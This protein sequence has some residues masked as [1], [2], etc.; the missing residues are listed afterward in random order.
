MSSPA[1]KRRLVAGNW[2]MNLDL[3][4]GLA[5]A[6]E[7]AAALSPVGFPVVLCAPAI[8]LAPLREIV[9][10][11]TDLALGAQD[12]SRHES[13]AHTGEVSGA[14]LRSA[15]CDYVIVGHSE[16]RADHVE[17][18]AVLREKV[19]R[20][21]AVGLRPIYCFGETLEQRDADEVE[22]V[23]A[24]QLAEGLSHLDGDA[25]GRVVLAYEPVWAIGTG[26]TASPEQAQEVHA[27]VRE[28]VGRRFGGTRAEHVSILY[29]GSVKPGNAAE[30][31]G[32]ADIDGGLIGGASLRA[33][34]V[35]AIV[36]AFV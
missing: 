10:E 29:G 28:W 19:D 12:L 18:G 31:F 4:A 27:F 30:L 15:G 7:C 20:A 8:H 33:A 22:K 14:Q 35:L 26:R 32:Q 11:S 9:G 5:L 3:D 2:K 1:S 17:A 13:G 25:F 6:R 16:R 34:D 21:L 23:V 24:D 36:G